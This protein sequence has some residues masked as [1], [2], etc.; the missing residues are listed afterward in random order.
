M[1]KYFIYKYINGGIFLLGILKMNVTQ[2]IELLKAMDTISKY[3]C[4]KALAFSYKPN[5]I[6]ADWDLI[7]EC[8]DK[9]SDAKQFIFDL[10]VNA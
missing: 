9:I 6:S 8:D 7:Q 4:E 5:D 1:H 3:E 10:V 2:K